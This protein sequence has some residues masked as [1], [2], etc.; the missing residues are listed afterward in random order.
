V[1]GD[2][3]FRG[4]QRLDGG[5]RTRLHEPDAT[6]ADAPAKRSAR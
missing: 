4:E 3:G 6:R 1:L 2:G 5:S